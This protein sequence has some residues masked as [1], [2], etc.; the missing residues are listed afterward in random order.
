VLHFSR[1]T[2]ET[3]FGC[4]S[5]A[6]MSDKALAPVHYCLSQQVAEPLAAAGARAIRIA[7]RPNEAALIDL[8]KA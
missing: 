1:R 4:A 7:D 2:A 6:G 5:A 3:Y 8:I